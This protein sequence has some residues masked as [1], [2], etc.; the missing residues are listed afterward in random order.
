MAQ[1]NYSSRIYRS[2]VAWR[3]TGQRWKH[4]AAPVCLLHVW[5]ADSQARKQKATAE[6]WK[7][8]YKCININPLGANHNFESCQYASLHFKTALKQP[9]YW[10]EK[11]S[12]GDKWYSSP[13]LLRSRRFRLFDVLVR[14]T[15]KWKKMFSYYLIQSESRA[16]GGLHASRIGLLHDRVP[17]VESIRRCHTL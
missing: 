13:D 12:E 3:W 15:L 4:A 8:M 14:R 16:G 1:S 17:F 5:R 2:L 10:W 11:M 7:V 6:K 9:Q